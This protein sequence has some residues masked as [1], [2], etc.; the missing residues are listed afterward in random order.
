MCVKTHIMVYS[1]ANLDINHYTSK[2]WNTANLLIGAGIKQSEFPKLMMPFFALVLLESRIIQK[3]KEILKEDFDTEEI[4]T[5][6][7]KQKSAFIQE[8]I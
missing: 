4:S 3:M 6:S 5:L 8:F 2:I 1:M 7:E